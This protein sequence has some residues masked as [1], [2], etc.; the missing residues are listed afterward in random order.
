MDMS[1]YKDLFVSEVR[2]H[3]Q[4]M[5][6]AIVSLEEAPED[7]EHID[8]LFRMAHSIKGMSASMGYGE[9]AEISHKMEDLMDRVRKGT[10]VFVSAVA[11]LLLEGSDLLSVMLNDV[12]AGGN[13]HQDILDL[14]QRLTDYTPR[15][16]EPP[17]PGA[18]KAIE[19]PGSAT[20]NQSP[21]QALPKKLEQEIAREKPDA[22]QNVR[23]KTE[24]LDAL[25]NI[26]GELIT[27]KN[28]MITLAN[29]MKAPALTEAISD[30]SHLVRE[31]QNEVLKVRLMPLATVV[32]HLP[33][34]VRDLA[35]KSGK[36]VSLQISGKEIE[37][38][39][40]IVEELSDPL[41]HILRNAVDHGL[42]L[43]AERLAM[44]KKPTGTISVAV[45]R[46]KDRVL[47]TISDDGKGM[48]TRRLIA[49]AI[50]KGLLRQEDAALLSPQQALMLT[51][52]PGFSTATEITDVSGRGVGMDA[53][54]SSVQAIGGNLAIDSSP[55]KGS[56]FTLS[57]PL[58]ISIIQI[59]LVACSS[60][61]VGLPVTKVLRT[62]EIRKDL[63]LS[64]GKGK[65]FRLGDEEIPL[66]SLHRLLALPLS[67]LKGE[68]IPAVVVEMKER[69]VGLVV[70]R[71][72]G[73][74]DV[75]VKPFGSPL[76]RMKG[77]F[78]G[79]VLGDG[80]VIFIIDPGNLL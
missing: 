22:P 80:Q 39:R 59:L 9:M 32:D 40:G 11:D 48:D 23:V 75:F 13:G 62:V 27:H 53:V 1:P 71:F 78:G 50:D 41:L 49:A 19:T 77:F 30:L 67:P 60:M 17:Q 57:L 24:I 55:G 79:A 15:D 35:K 47:I 18:G 25:V 12:D 4:G 8:F 66:V 26:T 72:V 69:T 29:E 61:I 6:E 7:R 38:D 51:C 56:C 73:Q 63:V 76:N 21:D 33:R 46:E 37:L 64:R 3:L 34:I 70:D 44:G 36:E 2:E 31:L 10:I 65:F 58:T 5:N 52:L 45:Q 16:F 54:R 14:S 68:S 20:T 28:R 42:E 74:Q 43:P